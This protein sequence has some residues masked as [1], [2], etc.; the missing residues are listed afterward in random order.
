MTIS[1]SCH[2]CYKSVDRTSTFLLD[3]NKQCYIRAVNIHTINY[4]PQKPH[5]LDILCIR[6]SIVSE[7]FND[8]GSKALLDPGML[9][10]TVDDKAEGSCRL[11]MDEQQDKGMIFRRLQF[12]RLKH[13]NHGQGPI[14]ANSQRL[15][16]YQSIDRLVSQKLSV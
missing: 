3:Y 16:S 10:E 8:F 5:A 14:M 12:L 2:D 7:Y 13:S 15:T 11:C 4:G 1:E 6:C 9:R